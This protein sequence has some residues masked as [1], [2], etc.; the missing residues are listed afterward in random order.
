[1]YTIPPLK[2]SSTSEDRVL[3]AGDNPF[4][5]DAND[6]ET[7]TS[8]YD[9]SKAIKAKENSIS[10]LIILAFVKKLLNINGILYFMSLTL[11]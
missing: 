11:F 8:Q 10:I 6:E 3:D 9:D 1:M 4:G 7:E 2:V 5:D